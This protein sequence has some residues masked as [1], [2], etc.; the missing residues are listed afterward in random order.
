MDAIVSGCLS[1]TV[2]RLVSEAKLRP[3]RDYCA[4]QGAEPWSGAERDRG[5][6]RHR[7]PPRQPLPGSESGRLRH[8][9][10]GR[11]AA[12][13]P[14]RAL[15]WTAWR[16]VGCHSVAPRSLLRLWG[17]SL[18]TV[19]G[20]GNNLLRRR[21]TVSGTLSVWAASPGCAGA[22]LP[23]ILPS[24][25][26]RRAES[27]VPRT[28]CG[29][30]QRATSRCFRP[31]GRPNLCGDLYHGALANPSAMESLANQLVGELVWCSAGRRHQQLDRIERDRASG[32]PIGA[33]RLI[34][35]GVRWGGQ[36]EA[37]R[38]GTARSRTSSL[39][40]MVPPNFLPTT[41][42]AEMILFTATS[43]LAHNFVCMCLPAQL[44]QETVYQGYLLRS[45]AWLR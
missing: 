15:I 38:A 21:N 41:R 45:Q 19:G 9:A 40:M 2:S 33:L 8:V 16:A 5:S 4:P 24:L 25:W 43:D 28:V 11:R 32:L 36:D 27:E 39:L 7:P 3:G 42:P 29:L 31:T 1:R 10:R 17:C 44:E 30:Q 6:V 22:P 18:F 13:H 37:R 35:G 26:G 12:A 23:V 20:A 14:A 34:L